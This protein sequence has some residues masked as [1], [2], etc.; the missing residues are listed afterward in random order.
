MDLLDNASE[1]LG[2]GQ[3]QSN[4][5]SIVVN[6]LIISGWTHV[7][8]HAGVEIMPWEAQLE[9]TNHQ[10]DGPDLAI[11]AGDEC[12]V[13]IGKTRILTGYIQT[14][15]SE[16]STSN[17]LLRIIVKSRSVDLVECSAEFSTYQ[18][19]NTTALGIIQQVCKPFGIT[20]S[21]EGGEGRTTIQQ[22]S[23]IL[24]ETAYEV[25]ERVCRLAACIF[26][27]MPDG[28]ILLASVGSNH[29]ASGLVQGQNVE[30]ATSLDTMDGRYSSIQAIIQNPAVLFTP[31]EDG[32][33]HA[34]QMLAQTAPVQASA[35]DP[36]VTRHRP[37]LIPVETGDADYAVAKK[38]V[39]WEAARRYGR[40][41]IVQVTVD[42]WCDSRGT[43]WSPNWLAHCE[44]PS[45]KIK[46]SLLISEVVLV[47]DE[48][49]THASITL[50]PPATFMPEPI[51]V[52]LAQNEG[53]AAITRG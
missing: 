15:T 6:G 1:F 41:Q 31:P 53:V 29:H 35:T 46:R 7:E 17:H 45:L 36:A 25:I 50:M 38:R 42:S 34:Q 30:H 32:D 22:F 19:N 37:M 48:Q 10:P 18:M 21:A 51:L 43:L 2:Y 20:V 3:A 5:A 13:L 4:A 49:G 9:T 26:H 40:S 23:V 52:P 12:Q 11:A 44:I 8:I 33:K 14:I 28:S 47:Q 24:T 39:Q 16:L 27:D